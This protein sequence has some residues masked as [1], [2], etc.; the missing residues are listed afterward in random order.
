MLI[1]ASLYCIIVETQLHIYRQQ[2]FKQIVR[3]QQIFYMVTAASSINILRPWRLQSTE[4]A[5]QWEYSESFKIRRYEVDQHNRAPIQSCCAFMEEAAG[6]HA[7]VLGFGVE[8]LQEL[9]ITWVLA[10]MQLQI[11]DFPISSEE[12]LVKTWTVEVEKLQ[13]RR[14][15]LLSGGDGRELVRAVT[16]W[17]II[18][19]ESRKL[20]KMPDF[21]AAC[22][23]P[24]AERVM[25]KEKLRIDAQENAP[26]LGTF[27]VRKADIDRNLHVN[28]VRFTDWMLESVPAE[29]SEQRTLSGL[30]IIYRAEAIYGDTAVSRGA[31]GEKDGEF[32]HGLYR[33]SDGQELVRAKSIWK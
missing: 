9:G 27:K 19:L 1:L 11:F 18:D 26:A 32:L 23:S 33:Q 29:Y 8:R 13:F 14:D 28:N 6:N 15:F 25:E 4:L 20:K 10:R 21:I 24:D 5:M 17:V 22:T 30:Q 12:V 31:C 3:C 2:E 7:A 16:D